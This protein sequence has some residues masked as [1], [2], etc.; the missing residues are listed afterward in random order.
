MAGLSSHGKSFAMFFI[1]PEEFNFFFSS[2]EQMIAWVEKLFESGGGGP[3]SREVELK[4][5]T[6]MARD[7]R[8][9]AANSGN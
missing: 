1:R 9:L 4:S 2:L 7:E 3:V 8:L 6:S 5:P